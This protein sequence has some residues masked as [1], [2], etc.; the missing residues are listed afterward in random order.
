MSAALLRTALHFTALALL[1]ACA[2]PATGPTQQHEWLE[3]GR[4]LDAT[5]ESIVELM[6]KHRVPGLAIAFN[7][8]R[9]TAHL[10]I[11][12]ANDLI[13]VKPLK[14]QFDRAMAQR[15][16]NDEIGLSCS[17]CGQRSG[18]GSK[19]KETERDIGTARTNRLS[20]GDQR[21]EHFGHL[22]R[23]GQFG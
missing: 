23:D 14:R 6:D 17:Q 7:V 10:R 11:I 21:G 1:V 13:P 2:G 15:C 9:R 5:E 20:D 4:T 18:A 12:K 3:D 8:R 22:R 16:R 19:G